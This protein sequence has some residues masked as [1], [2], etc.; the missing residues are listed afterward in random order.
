MWPQADARL[1]SAHPAT[2]RRAWSRSRSQRRYSHTPRNTTSSAIC[3]HFGLLKIGTRRV[4]DRRGQGEWEESGFYW[5]RLGKAGWEATEAGG[6]KEKRCLLAWSWR[7]GRSLIFCGILSSPRPLSFLNA[8]MVFVQSKEWRKG[9]QSGGGR[10][11][12]IAV[13]TQKRWCFHHG[14]GK[15]RAHLM[16]TKATLFFLLIFLNA[17]LRWLFNMQH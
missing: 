12:I 17:G 13:V 15:K 4:V 9:S 2:H 14:E 1:H 7:E 8:Q 6:E 10:D 5:R 11:F 16:D 3:S